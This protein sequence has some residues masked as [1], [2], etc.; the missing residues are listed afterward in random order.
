M[1]LRAPWRLLRDR[2]FIVVM[3]VTAVFNIWCFPLIT[4]VPVIAQKDFG[5][6]PAMVGALA[7]LEGV[8]GTLGALIIGTIA[9]QRTLF[10]FYYWGVTAFLVLALVLS[11]HLTVPF[12]V[13]MLLAMGG[14]AAGFSATQYAL[15]HVSVPAETRGRA[16]GLLSIFIGTSII[17]FTIAGELFARLGSVGAMRVMGIAGLAMMALL[18]AAW[19]AGRGPEA[20]T[21]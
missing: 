8:G 19:M 7:A 11:T 3:G 12:A 13:V 9:T 17:G 20:R 21:T 6:T 5:M 4:M 14:A 10:R 18:G 1:R 16:A 15:V 2:R